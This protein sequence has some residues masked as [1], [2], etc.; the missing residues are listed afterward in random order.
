MMCDRIAPVTLPRVSKKITR[1][2]C[3][4]GSLC[5]IG[6]C[7][8]TQTGSNTSFHFS[9][10]ALT[11]A[12]LAEAYWL[13]APLSSMRPRLFCWTGSGA[14]GNCEPLHG[15]QC[16]WEKSHWKLF[17]LFSQTCLKERDLEYLHV[18]VEGSYMLPSGK[19]IECKIKSLT[20]WWIWK[21]ND[22][23]LDLFCI[24]LPRLLLPSVGHITS[25]PW[26]FLASSHQK[27][28]RKSDGLCN[29]QGCYFWIRPVIHLVF[30]RGKE[31]LCIIKS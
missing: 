17:R 30:L 27:A 13:S 18:L 8:E 14:L 31:G 4:Q 23:L 16:S 3:G 25:S 1:C 10:S 9:F 5:S 29:T 24:L 19:T 15:D 7:S 2:S 21:E 22:R 12:W 20:N 6:D 26:R 11:W 28:G